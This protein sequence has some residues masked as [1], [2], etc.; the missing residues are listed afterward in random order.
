MNDTRKSLRQGRSNPLA[1]LKGTS[2]AAWVPIPRLIV[3][4]GS[5]QH[6]FAWPSKVPGTFAIIPQRAAQVHD[7]AICREEVKNG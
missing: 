3:G 7:R 1:F 5:V 2:V 4:Y 6:S